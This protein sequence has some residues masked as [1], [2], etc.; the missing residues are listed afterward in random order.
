MDQGEDAPE[1]N[2]KQFYAKASKSAGDA[3]SASGKAA[4][5]V[6]KANSLYYKA[7]TLT[8][9]D[10]L[11]D[12]QKAAQDAETLFRNVPQGEQGQAACLH[13]IGSLCMASSQ[14][15]KALDTLD[16]ALNLSQ[17]AGDAE[18]EYAIALTTYNIQKQVA[19][20][21]MMSGGVDPGNDG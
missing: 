17:T 4:E 15:D 6:A 3:V 14:V 7:N 13:L 21:V 19:P 11:T 2:A 8:L 20:P 18:L 5:K 1:K 16:K 10:K 9:E 12:A